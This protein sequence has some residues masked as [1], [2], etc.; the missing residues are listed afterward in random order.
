[1]TTNRRTEWT[2][3]NGKR[4]AVE[5]GDGAVTTYQLLGDRWVSTYGYAP[6]P[7]ALES[8]DAT[9]QALAAEVE[10]LATDLE[11]SYRRESLGMVVQWNNS[12]CVGS[13]VRA[14]ALLSRLGVTK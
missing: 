6:W 10:R 5:T 13:A 7:D 14:R 8:R 9:I 4:W 11:T 12:R 2:D 1:M 3:R